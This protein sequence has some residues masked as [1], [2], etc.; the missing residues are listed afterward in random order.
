M[1]FLRTTMRAQVAGATGFFVPQTVSRLFPGTAEM[2]VVVVAK[3]RPGGSVSS[4]DIDAFII[5][6]G[7]YTGP[8]N[9]GGWEFGYD[10]F[11]TADPEVYLGMWD[12]AAQ[13]LLHFGESR[14]ILAADEGKV[15]RF[16]GVGAVAGSAVGGVNG[17]VVMYTNGEPGASTPGFDDLLPSFLPSPSTGGAPDSI[18]VLGI[19]DQSSG[20]SYAGMTQFEVMDLAVVANRAFTATEVKQLD[21]LIMATGGIPPGFADWTEFYQAERLVGHP[22]V[23]DAGGLNAGFGWPAVGA[24]PILGSVLIKPGDWGGFGV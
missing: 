19:T 10:R 17:L 22:L 11:T 3:L 9:A 21:K 20:I 1:Q 23:I 7:P 6:D 13:P 2:S 24:E 16:V 14:G 4:V 12:N 18:G 5:R 15:H 8:N